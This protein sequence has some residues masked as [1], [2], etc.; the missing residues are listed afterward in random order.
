MYGTPVIANKQAEYSYSIHV[1][2]L[3][4]HTLFIRTSRL[5]F[6]QRFRTYIKNISETS[7]TFIVFTCF[8]TY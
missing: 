4:E 1:F 2:F 3:S 8:A 5:R 6:C 7:R